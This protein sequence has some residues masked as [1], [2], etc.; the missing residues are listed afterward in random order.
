[1]SHGELRERAMRVQ[2]RKSRKKE[3]IAN[4]GRRECWVSNVAAPVE[5]V[6]SKPPHAVTPPVAL[7]FDV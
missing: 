5:L 3:D 4:L 7:T 2:A 1:M 6:E